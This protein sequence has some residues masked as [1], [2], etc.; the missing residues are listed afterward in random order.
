MSESLKISHYLAVSG[1]I[2]A[3]GFAAG[4]IL[5]IYDPMF[6]ESLVNLFEEMIANQIMSAEPPLLALQLFLNNLEACVIIF[7]GGAFFGFISVAIL[8]LNGVIIG[9]VLEV[10]QKEA[11]YLAIIAAILPHGIFE[12]PAVIAS[13]A[14]GLMMGRAVKNELA[15]TSDA[16]FEALRLGRYFVKYIIPF[17]AIAAIIEAF[18]TP[19]I[20]Q[21]VT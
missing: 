19:A 20:L 14:L 9:A 17:I 21:L 18:I 11:G 2:L 10:I 5:S 3:A 13:G 7:I 16:S 8:M 12:L 1:L 4:F 15:G 6:G